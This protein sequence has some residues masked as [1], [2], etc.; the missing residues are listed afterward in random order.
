MFKMYIPESHFK[1]ILLLSSLSSFFFFFL[2]CQFQCF[3]VLWIT[4]LFLALSGWWGRILT[5]SHLKKGT[6]KTGGLRTDVQI[7]SSLWLIV[8]ISHFFLYTDL[9]QLAKAIFQN[10]LGLWS[11][12]YF[13]LIFQ[14]SV[15]AFHPQGPLHWPHIL[16][17]PQIGSDIPVLYSALLYF[18]TIVFI[19]IFYYS[20]Q[21]LFDYYRS[22]F[23]RLLN[24]LRR[25]MF[26]YSCT[27]SLE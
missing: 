6:H 10:H 3:P 13:F 25:L 18:L 19:T 23:T 16:L 15:K 11:Y 5:Y 8:H 1:C 14:I 17:L 27:L 9:T 12:F 7:V 26:S 22:P 20:S 24:S 4:K 21:H 2:T